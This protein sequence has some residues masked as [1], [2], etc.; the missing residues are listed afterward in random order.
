[1]NASSAISVEAFYKFYATTPI[2]FYGTLY[3]LT[4]FSCISISMN[5]IAYIILRKNKFQSSKIITYLRY[6]VFN[7]LIISLM[8]LTRFTGTN[9]SLFDFSNSYGASAYASFFFIPFLSI[10]YL[11]GNLLDIYITIERI[12]HLVPNNPLKRIVKI[13]HFWSIMI[14]ASLF[15]NIPNFF[16]SEPF[17]LYLKLDDGTIILKY[18]TK[19]TNFSTSNLGKIITY[20]IY[21]IRDILTL[22]VKIIINIYAV[23]L[24][25]KYFYKIKSKNS[26]S[27]QIENSTNLNT[28]VSYTKVDRNLTFISITMCILSSFENIFYIASYVKAAFKY[29]DTLLNLYFFSN[30][31]IAIKHSSNLIILYSF[32][33]VFKEEFKKLFWFCIQF[34]KI[35]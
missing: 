28:K 10:F 34:K 12:Q 24:I 26:V 4:P 30:V 19:P 8:L 25:R 16:I 31:M 7:S 29:D 5:L 3:G 14:I 20:M 15:I 22:V 33:S 6:N 35:P 32:N 9:Y 2:A 13:K 18:L 1:M 21:F 11:N 23:V 17:Y 27:E